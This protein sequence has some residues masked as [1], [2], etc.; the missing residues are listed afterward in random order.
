MTLRVLWDGRTRPFLSLVLRAFTPS[1]LPPG[2][3]WPKEQQ[4]PEGGTRRQEASRRPGTGDLIRGWSGNWGHRNPRNFQV[5]I[6]NAVAGWLSN[7][8]AAASRGRG[9]AAL[10]RNSQGGISSPL[11]PH[12]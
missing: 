2:K 1:L 10:R 9:S 8:R 6:P 4:V 12:P 3:F 5:E 11:I 7:R